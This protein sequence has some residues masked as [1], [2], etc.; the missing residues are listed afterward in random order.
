MLKENERLVKLATSYIEMSNGTIVCHNKMQIQRKM[1]VMIARYELY[2][3]A[4]PYIATKVPFYLR[5]TREKYTN[6]NITKIISGLYN[7]RK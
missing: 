2:L 6:S 5:I 3:V 7:C 1:N 4:F